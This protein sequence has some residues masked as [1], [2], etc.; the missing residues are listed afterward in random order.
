MRMGQ[1]QERRNLTD[2]EQLVWPEKNRLMN[3]KGLDVALLLHKWF[4]KVFFQE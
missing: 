1:M 2:L 3:G 4:W